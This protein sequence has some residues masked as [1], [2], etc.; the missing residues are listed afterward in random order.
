IEFS[1]AVH[2]EM[3][4]IIGIA[5]TGVAG[6]KGATL[7]TTVYPCHNCA[8][9]IVAAGISRVVFIEPY[10]KS[11]AS[12]LHNDSIFQESEAAADA[13]HTEL[14]HFVHFEGVSPHKFSRLFHAE[15]PRK[16]KSG[17][18]LEFPL[19][20]EKRYTEFLDDYIKLEARVI[21]RL[22]QLET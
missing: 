8:R 2:A 18:A 13:P 20:R 17:A 4:A 21:E 1:R 5:R 14:V 3:D 11:L 22:D 16:D 10:E 6:I 9:H 7:F 15:Q 12:Q 19:T